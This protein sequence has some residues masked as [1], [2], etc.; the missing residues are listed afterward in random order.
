[1]NGQ[2]TK[3]AAAYV[4]GRTQRDAWPIDHVIV[5]H[6]DDGLWYATTRWSP[7]GVLLLASGIDE[8]GRKAIRIETLA[9]DE[10]ERTGPE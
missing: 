6:L 3:S 5:Y 9:S 4:F 7:V 2:P 10:Q 8:Q 1:M